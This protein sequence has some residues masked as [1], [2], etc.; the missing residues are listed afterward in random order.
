MAD[1]FRD[2]S[3]AGDW[4]QT[5]PSGLDRSCG[6]ANGHAAGLKGKNKERNEKEEGKTKN[7]RRKGLARERQGLWPGPH[8]PPPRLS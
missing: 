7:V 2:R 4:R 6:H 5:Q 3:G 1:N 8:G